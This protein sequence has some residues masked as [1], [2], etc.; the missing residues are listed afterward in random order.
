MVSGHGGVGR[1]CRSQRTFSS[2]N[3]SVILRSRA[4]AGGAGPRVL[5]WRGPGLWPWCQQMVLKNTECCPRPEGSRALLSEAP[6]CS[7][8]TPGP[9]GKVHDLGALGAFSINLYEDLGTIVWVSRD[10]REVGSNLQMVLRQENVRYR[11]GSFILIWQS[12]P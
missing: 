3:D 10:P 1:G 2:R 7:A 6:R 4:A 12:E 8:V 11:Q 9:G 5:R